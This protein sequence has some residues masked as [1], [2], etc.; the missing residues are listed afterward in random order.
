MPYKDKNKE[1]LRWVFKSIHKRCYK[2]H[3]KDYKNY[4]AKG[5]EVC[6]EWHKFIPFHDWAMSNGYK[7]GLCID[8]KNSKLNYKPS[9]C[10][11]VSRADSNAL[12]FNRD[13]RKTCKQGH[14]WKR[15]TIYYVKAGKTWKACKICSAARAKAYYLKRKKDSK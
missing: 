7:L 13:L 4:G 15:K 2:P 14:P 11:W 12:K 10:R 3:R 6:K 1:K 8:R 9:N 5:I